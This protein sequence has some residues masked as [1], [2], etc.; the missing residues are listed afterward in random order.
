MKYILIFCLFLSGCFYWDHLTG[1]VECTNV[2]SLEDER[3]LD[4]TERMQILDTLPKIKGW[5][6]KKCVHSKV[7]DPK[8]G[9]FMYCEYC[10]DE[11]QMWLIY[12]YEGVGGGYE[13]YPYTPNDSVCGDSPIKHL[14]MEFDII[15]NSKK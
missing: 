15:R 8:A 1:N 12:D 4:L 5:D 6:A 7:I 9:E 11:H 14:S 10:K 3:C 13:W 2:G